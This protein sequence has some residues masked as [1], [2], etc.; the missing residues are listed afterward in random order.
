MGASVLSIEQEKEKAVKPG[1]DFKECATGCPTM[2][3]VRAGR[4]MM[5]SPI[6][7]LGSLHPQREVTIAKPFAVGKT[8]VTFA[9]WDSCVAAGACERARDSGWGRDDRPVIDVNWNDA[10][11]YVAWLSRITGKEYRLLTEAEWEYAARA[12]TTTNYSWGDDV[13]IGNANCEGCGS[14]WGGK[15]TAPVGSFK[16]NAFGLHD[17][18]GNVW[19]WVQDPWHDDNYLGLPPT[20]GSAWTEG[21]DASRRVVRGGSWKGDPRYLRAANCREGPTDYRGDIL[22]FRLAR[23]LNP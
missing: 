19:E 3:V 18:H 14:Q 12:G 11:Q 22:G 7:M 15:Q 23:T 16:P 5:G 4:F 2:I 13:G 6:Y 21:G 17:M 1:S 20:N 8:E 10:Q 9:E